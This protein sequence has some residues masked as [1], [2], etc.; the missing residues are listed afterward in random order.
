MSSSNEIALACEEHANA[1]EI[2]RAAKAVANQTGRAVVLRARG[3]VVREIQP[4]NVRKAE[5]RLRAVKTG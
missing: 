5:P 4:D 2:L 3:R 1:P